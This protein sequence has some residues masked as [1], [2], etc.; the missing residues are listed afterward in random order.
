MAVEPI[1]R[2]ELVE[3]EMEGNREGRRDGP[4]VKIRQ[5]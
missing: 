2:I 4:G 1:F 3:E 5:D